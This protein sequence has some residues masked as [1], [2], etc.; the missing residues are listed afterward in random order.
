MREYYM[1]GANTFVYLF[2]G[3]GMVVDRR[4]HNVLTG[5]FEFVVHD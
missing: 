2:V 1:P 5:A 4:C 3:L